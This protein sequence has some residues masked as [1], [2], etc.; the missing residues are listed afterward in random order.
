MD[1][2]SL[3]AVHA[4]IMGCRG[5]PLDLDASAVTRF[6]GQ[7]LQLVLSAFRTWREDGVHLR[8]CN[9]SESVRDAFE[10][11][12]CLPHVELHEAAA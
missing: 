9:P 1:A 7:A 6:G 11:L 12:G 5:A 3:A 2:S 10:T 8:V 4:E